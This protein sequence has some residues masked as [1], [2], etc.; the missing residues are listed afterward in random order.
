[1]RTASNSQAARNVIENAID[2]KNRSRWGS[3]SGKS[4]SYNIACAIHGVTQ[5]S[6]FS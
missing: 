1:V 2:K 5:Q 3:V 6:Q 4:E